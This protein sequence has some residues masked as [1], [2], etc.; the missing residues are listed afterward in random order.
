MC[1]RVGAGGVRGGLF[2]HLAFFSFIAL[3][4]GSK[5]FNG[6]SCQV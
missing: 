6:L 1:Q 2:D 3:E 5:G 4:E